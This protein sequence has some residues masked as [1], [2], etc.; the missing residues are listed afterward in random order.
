L[1]PEAQTRGFILMAEAQRVIDQ[2]QNN[3]K[4]IEMKRVIANN[5]I[6][7]Q[8]GPWDPELIHIE[9]TT[10]SDNLEASTP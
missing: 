3:P 2:L 6:K 10:R 8:G 9:E 5:P 1:T 7:I 4:L